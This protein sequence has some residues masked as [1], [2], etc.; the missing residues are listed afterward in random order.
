MPTSSD[1]IVVGVD[2]GTTGTK[3]CA[4]DGHGALLARAYYSYSICSP[5]PSWAEQDP[6]GIW[7]AVVAAIKEVVACLSAKGQ[8][9]SALS[10]SSAFHSLIAI[11]AAG[12][13]ISPSLTWADNRSATY[14]AKLRSADT[15]DALSARTGLPLLPMSPLTKLVWM[16]DHQRGL[17]E[18]A[19]GFISI[20]EYVL[21]Q[22]TGE[23]LTDLTM[24][25][26]TGLFDVRKHRWD[27]EALSIA[28]ITTRHLPT[29]VEP[30]TV[31]P[32]LRKIVADHLGV[33]TRLPVVVGAGDGLLANIGSGAVGIG[34]A[35]LTIGTS[36]GLRSVLPAPYSD[37]HGK[38]ICYAVTNDRW[39]VGY[40]GS[41]GGIVLDWMSRLFG[42]EDDKVGR[43]ELMDKAL[44]LTPGADGLICL[45]Y[46]VGER[47]PNRDAAAKGA[48]VG[49]RI[50][51][52][53]EHY[54]RAALEG[55]FLVARGM[56]DAL[57][58]LTGPVSDIHVSGGVLRE[59]GVLNL[60]ADCL[61]CAISVPVSHDSSAFGAALLAITALDGR[62]D[63]D[64][65]VQHVF[66]TQ[67][68][69]TGESADFYQQRV[70]VE[71]N[72]YALLQTY[73]QRLS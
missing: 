6:K 28:G 61:G 32:H 2:I 29:F 5:Y 47:A 23:R 68:D 51:H 27:D 57:A 38:N 71:N 42:L 64:A 31:V 10:L 41:S 53:R 21:E 25:S 33:P 8:T 12:S 19:K 24:A 30:T 70:G 43:A 55:I 44:R 35:N 67:V 4:V 14:A 66:T 58:Q 3:A 65:T 46:I 72:L 17:F 48:F 11:D 62:C 45:P 22:L 20:K 40:A 18:A 13:P 34:K 54:W 1:A 56:R 9:I 59:P 73:Q 37:P 50:D 16:K 69:C 36:L 7:E 49:M 39:L 15:G 52:G 63:L 60:L 26:A